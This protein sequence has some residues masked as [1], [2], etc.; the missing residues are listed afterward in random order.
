MNANGGAIRFA[1]GFERDSLE[2]FEVES[3]LTLAIATTHPQASLQRV[4]DGKNRGTCIYTY[5]LRSSLNAFP[6][7]SYI[8]F[9]HVTGS[10]ISGINYQIDVQPLTTECVQCIRQ[11]REGREKHK[12]EM[13]IRWDSVRKALFSFFPSCDLPVNPKYK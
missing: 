13:G 4:P 3:S 5:I 10:S 12:I 1:D 8:S 7:L 2:L 6:F 9:P 11:H